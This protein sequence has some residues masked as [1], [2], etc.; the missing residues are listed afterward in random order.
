MRIGLFGGTF[1]PVHWGH[2]RAAE[3]IREMFD[4]KQIIFI[5]NNISPHKESGEIVPAYHR[6]RMLDLAVRDN[7]QFFTSDV[8]LKR[9]GKSYSIETISHFKHTLGAELTPFFILG[10]DAFLEITSWKN[11]QGLFSL[12]NF[13]VMSRPRYELEELHQVI[14]TQVKKDFRYQPDE[15]RFIHSS[16]FSIYFTEITL[17]DISS[18]SIRTLIKGGRSIKYLLPEEVENY[19]KEHKFYM[20]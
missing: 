16:H 13:I 8:E 1:N 20:A 15:N 3:E 10:T 9:P 6:L 17:I 5:P 19:V 2:L 14:P 4:L 7:P 18:H 11:Y 12:C